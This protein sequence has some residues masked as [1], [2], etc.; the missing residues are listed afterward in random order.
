MSNSQRKVVLVTG[1]SS[2]IGQAI[3]A[4]LQA[5]GYR[6]F[7]TH[8]QAATVNGINLIS[9]NVDD[10][11]SVQQGIQTVYQTA[12]RLD[13]VVN[14][15]GWAVLGAVED[16]SLA[17]AKAQF[18]TNFFG[19]LRV[20]K[21]VLPIMRQQRCGHI[22][23]ISSLGGILGTPFS[24]LYCATKFAVEGMS[25]SLRFET[26]QF[27]VRVV[28]IEPG[29]FKTQFTTARRQV[30]GSKSSEVYRASFTRFM[31]TQAKDEANA[32]TP[33]PIAEL[34]ERILRN[35][36]PRLRYS[37][38]MASQRIVIPMKRYLPQG[39]FEW[40]LKQVFQM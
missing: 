17:E 1:A 23:N 28:L 19:V 32:P 30:E 7:G 33:E 4:H 22:I 20:N 35:P 29:D 27:G 12:G 37:V 39:V 13:A 21:A 40:V 9:M 14:N 11:Q 5:R 2:G 18:E 6:V 34:V 31:A 36:N 8:R 26:R 3:A 24:G 16:T 10:D 15:A 25:E 38:G